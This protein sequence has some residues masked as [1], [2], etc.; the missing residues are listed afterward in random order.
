MIIIIIMLVSCK[1][2][3]KIA[4]ENTA[5]I[6]TETTKEFTR[7]IIEPAF[8]IFKSISEKEGDKSCSFSPISLDLAFAMAY[9]GTANNTN[10]EIAEVL[11]F[12]KNQKIFNTEIKKYYSQLKHFEKDTNMQFSIANRIFFDNTFLLKEEYKKTVLNY[13]DND[14][15]KQVDFKNNAHI[16]E[17]NINQWVSKITREKI[18]NL[19]PSGTL[20]SQTKSVLVN[21]LYFK[22]EW[23]YTFN[24]NQTEEKNFFISDEKNKKIPFMKTTQKNGILFYQNENIKVIELP[25]K[26][27]NISLIIILPNEN[28]SKNVNNFIPNETEY[29]EICKNL[30]NTPLKIELPKF[31]TESSFE[32][33]KILI[34]HGMKEVFKNGDFSNMT[35]DKSLVISAVLQKVFFEV[36]EKGSEA[37]AA[38][39]LLIRTTS[40]PVNQEIIYQNFIADHPFIY[41]LKE[42]FSNTPLFIGK[43]TE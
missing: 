40:A 39:A 36:D 4:I 2:K 8:K 31:K 29:I 30:K 13:A 10:K 11:G 20:S 28:T 43:Y 37:A 27:K 38:T 17:N 1:S 22:S 7:S 3:E 15:L 24:K 34:G 35:N 33:S 32:L 41:I 42:N 23:L 5:E 6:N 18:N 14:I 25:Y 21:A 9:S 19:I 12:N 26:T 16:E